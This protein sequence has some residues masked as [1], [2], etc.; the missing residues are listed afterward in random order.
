MVGN[1]ASICGW[2]FKICMIDFVLSGNRY[3]WSAMTGSVMMVAGFEFIKMVSIPSSRKDLSAC[4]P[5]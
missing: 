3:T 4:D 1:T 2:A 5:E